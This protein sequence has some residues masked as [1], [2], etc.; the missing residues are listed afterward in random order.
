MKAVGLIV[1][2]AGVWAL[3]STAASAQQVEYV[4]VCSTY[5]QGFFYIPGTD[6]CLRVGGYVRAEWTGSRNDAGDTTY[7]WLGKLHPEV[8]A[9]FRTAYGTLH[10]YISGN[11]EFSGN[12]A[13]DSEF[14]AERDEAYLDFNDT[15]LVGWKAS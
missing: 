14:I 11:F 4:Q 7:G 9:R 13:G 15:F 2:S 3:A 10:A 1:A 6:T 5:G 12:S 8:D